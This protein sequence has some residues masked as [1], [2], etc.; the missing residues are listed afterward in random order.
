VPTKAHGLAEAAF[1]CVNA[2]VRIISVTTCAL[3]VFLVC[4]NG[5]EI[6]LRGAFSH[7]FSWIYDVNLL[8]SNWI[9]FL[10]MCLVYDSKKD[11][12]LDYLR[13]VFGAGAQKWIAILIN[14]IAAATFILIGRYTID[15]IQLQWPFR[16]S[17]YGIPQALYSIPLLI[18]TVVICLILA[19]Q[20]AEIL[21]DR[22]PSHAPHH[23]ARD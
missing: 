18:A 15:L 23:S 19:K 20:S 4:A 8:L 16:T 13:S 21:L 9:Y 17:G 10:G 1:T 5:L 14:V 3:L 6:L 11:I 2:L 22:N 12:S 7:S